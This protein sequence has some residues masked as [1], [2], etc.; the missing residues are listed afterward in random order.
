LIFDGEAKK[1]NK[2]TNKQAKNPTKTKTYNGK[3]RKHV[4]TIG[5]T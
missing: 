2:K 5:T 3:K 1:K 4:S